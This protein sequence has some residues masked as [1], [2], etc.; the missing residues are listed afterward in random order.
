MARGVDGVTVRDIRLRD[1]LAAR[2]DSRL[3]KGQGKQVDIRS[4]HGPSV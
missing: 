3:K 4:E 1:S 2:G